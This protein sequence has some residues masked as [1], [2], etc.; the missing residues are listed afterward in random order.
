VKLILQDRNCLHVIP[1]LA[2]QPLL[3]AALLQG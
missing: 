3:L 1:L 2:N